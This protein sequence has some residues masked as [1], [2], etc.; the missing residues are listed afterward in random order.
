[1]SM[2]N[3][4]VPVRPEVESKE[5]ILRGKLSKMKGALVGL[6]VTTVAAITTAIAIGLNSVKKEDHSFEDKTEVIKNES[7]SHTTPETTSEILDQL[8]KKLV[9]GDVS[10]EEIER[11][12]KMLDEDK[13]YTEHL[14]S[15]NVNEDGGTI[16][17]G[18]YVPGS[19]KVQW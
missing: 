1:M 3:S 7:W 17:T 9:L 6:S 18:G 19:E 14:K 13:A 10:D 4:G 8:D 15:L 12:N 5:E 16:E 11:I 2:E